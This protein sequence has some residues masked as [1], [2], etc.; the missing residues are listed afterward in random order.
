CRLSSEHRDRARRAPTTPRRRLLCA[1]TPRYQPAD[2][3]RERVELRQ[4]GRP[5][6]LVT[7]RALLPH[8]ASRADGDHVAP[9][10]LRARVLALRQQMLNR[11]AGEAARMLLGAQ[12]LIARRGPLIDA[13]HTVSAQLALL[14]T[15]LRAQGQTL[16]IAQI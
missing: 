13:R 6:G 7:M 3:P 9:Q 12:V 5:S 14:L 11:A 16:L 1:C 8:P 10:Q 15:Q 4:R 2:A